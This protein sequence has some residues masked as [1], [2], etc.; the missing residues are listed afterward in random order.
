[1]SVLEVGESPFFSCG[2]R[3]AFLCS[4]MPWS[5]CS[6]VGSTFS[7]KAKGPFLWRWPSLRLLA[8]T[9]PV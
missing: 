3:G 6:K 8:R 5:L 4:Q 2:Y 7:S 9:D 1:M